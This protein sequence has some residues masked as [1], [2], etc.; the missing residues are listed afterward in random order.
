MLQRIPFWLN[1][2]SNFIYKVENCAQMMSDDKEKNSEQCAYHN[3][4]R[5][6]RKRTQKQSPIYHLLSLKHFTW[7]W[8]LSFEHWLVYGARRSAIVHLV[9]IHTT[10]CEKK[11]ISKDNLYGILLLCPTSHSL[12]F[13]LFIIL[14]SNTHQHDRI[15][16]Y[17]RKENSSYTILCII[18][19]P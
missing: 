5:T 11:P 12:V 17:I 3:P 15:I 18:P 10:E 4:Q 6:L 7:P 13:L 9:F 2:N 14:I 8:F 16:C 19:I 1:I